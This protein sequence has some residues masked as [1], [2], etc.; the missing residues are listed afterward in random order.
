MP[1]KTVHVAAEDPAVR[2][3][4]RRTVQSY[5]V[6]DV[7]EMSAEGRAGA[8]IVGA[9][10]P[11]ILVLA[12]GG[13]PDPARHVGWYRRAAPGAYVVGFAFDR[14]ERDAL[15]A[16]GADAVVMSDIGKAGFLDVLRRA[17][18]RAPAG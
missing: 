15:A 9:T 17:E 1:H 12:M 7:V 13:E 10:Q 11:E 6:G 3:S 2:R 4:L 5:G 14:A 8:V 16:G 18:R